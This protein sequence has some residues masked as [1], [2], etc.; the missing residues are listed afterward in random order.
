MNGE[1]MAVR[2]WD[3]PTRT[4]HWV[5]AVCVFCSLGSAWIG[6]NAM[7]WHLRFGTL[8][9]ALVLF[10]LLWGFLGGR[11]SRFTSF[12]YAPATSLRY[13]RG[14]SRRDEWH[15]VGHSPL[16]SWSVF[17][18]LGILALQVA[19]GL[20][21]DDE[22]ATTGPLNKFV[23]GKTATLLTRWHTTAGQW[24]IIALIVLHVGAVLFY[25][26]RQRKNLIGPMVSGDKALAADV[27]G[28]I[29]TPASRLMALALF[30]TVGGL[31]LWLVSLGD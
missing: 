26:L 7:V 8:V 10:R 2:V 27:P 6:G 23:S 19:C 29:D 25:L 31:V 18:L 20:F 30:V 3:L 9:F 28:S 13:L 17:A 21:A 1:T 16:G 4:F 11:W 24:A 14:Q 22:I 5:L 15:D 12:A